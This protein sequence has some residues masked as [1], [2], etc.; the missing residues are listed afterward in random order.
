MESAVPILI[1]EA[2]VVNEGQIF[3]ADVLL[4]NGYID[5]IANSISGLQGN[6]KEIPAKGKYLLPGIIDNHVHFREPGLTHKG[7]IRSE[8]AAAV[9]GGVT[10]FMEMPNT[11]PQATTLDRVREKHKLA[12]KFSYNNYA[13]YLG[14]S[15]DNLE[16]IKQANEE[17]LCGVKIFMGSST[18]NMLVD[19]EATLSEIFGN[20]RHLVAIHAEDEAIIAENFKKVRQ[21]YGDE[22]PIEA[23]PEIRDAKACFEASKKAISLAREKNTRLHVLHLTTAD[24]I[25]LF[26][27]GG[28]P[29]SKQITT[30]VCVHHLH[31][32][33]ED[34][35]RLGNK[36]KCF[37]AIKNPEHRKALWEGL[38]EGSIDQI[39]SDHAPHTLKEKNQPHLEAP[40]GIPMIQFNLPLLL[41]YF[42]QGDI[43]LPVIVEKMCHN[44]ALN[45]QVEER[46]FLKE[47]YKAD[48]L[49]VDLNKRQP[50]NQENIFS[51]C[52][53]SPFEGRTFPASVTH[54]FVNGHLVYQEGAIVSEGKGEKL[55]FPR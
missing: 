8:S 28:R 2:L 42:R 5:R 44:P 22:I 47:G 21:K 13:F 18:G 6:F 20:S 25:P 35:E 46:G 19:D 11:I 53:W 45:Y 31:F 15:N 50:V 55:N 14:A 32:S 33:S 36:I 38:L 3:T 40:G 49:L 24:E 26:N 51:T 43:S 10:S 12:D 52:G 34:Y 41:E 37:P 48:C 16:E 30:E 23:H 7:T 54:T 9:A 39:A 17:N 4:N 27:E 29:G 1:K